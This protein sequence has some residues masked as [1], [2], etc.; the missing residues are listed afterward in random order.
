MI[1]HPSLI[2]I[3]ALVAV[4][5]VLYVHHRFVGRKSQSDPAEEEVEQKVPE[6]D[7]QECCGLHLTCEKSSLSPTFA[8][9][10]EYFDD[11]ELDV[12]ADTAAAEYSESDIERFREVLYTLRPEEIAPWARSVQMRRIELPEVVRDEL[13]IIVEEM[14]TAS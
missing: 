8:E 11:E 7:S 12:Y 1:M 5:T 4:G 14:R 13:F 10:V 3:A 6:E 9:K 2:L